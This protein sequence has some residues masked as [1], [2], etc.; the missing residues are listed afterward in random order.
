[1]IITECN[2]NENYGSYNYEAIGIFS[3]KR[4]FEHFP[5]GE[6]GVQMVCDWMEKYHPRTFFGGFS[7]ISLGDNKDNF[8]D[9]VFLIATERANLD[10]K[11]KNLEK[12]KKF[13]WK[14]LPIAVSDKKIEKWQKS[15]PSELILPEYFLKS[16]TI[17][18]LKEN[19]KKAQ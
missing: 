8:S 14:K 4:L 2:N 11:N 3:P 9:V 5:S 19:W 17:E 10:W 12:A 16:S 13:K 6:E 1:M 18:E 15:L 7:Y